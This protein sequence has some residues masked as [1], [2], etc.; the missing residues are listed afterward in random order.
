ML[1][2]AT[3]IWDTAPIASGAFWS[4]SQAACRTC[5]RAWSI[6][7]RASAIRS[8]AAQVGKRLAERHTLGGPLARQFECQLGKSDQPHAVMDPARSEPCLGDRKG[9]SRAADDGI[10][11]Q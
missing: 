7:M 4:T 10:R 1:G 5:S 11:G 9:L 2:T 6:A 8:V 3:L